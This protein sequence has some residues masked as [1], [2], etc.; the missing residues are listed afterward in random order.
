MPCYNILK[1]VILD[2]TMVIKHNI[3]METSIFCINK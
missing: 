2:L 1:W 3:L